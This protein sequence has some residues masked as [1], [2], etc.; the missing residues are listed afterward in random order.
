MIRAI[1]KQGKIHPIEALPGE[2]QEGQELLVDTTDE[3][4][5]QDGDQWLAELNAAAARIPERVHV[6]M[7][8]ALER[9]EEESKE[10]V[11]REMESRP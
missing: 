11:R 10:L 3:P 9:L 2:W 7:A 8:T 1:F 4:A 6:E 5:P